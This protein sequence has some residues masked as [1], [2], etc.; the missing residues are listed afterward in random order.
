[1]TPV[2][3]AMSRLQQ[4]ADSHLE[5]VEEPQELDL[6][7]LESSRLSLSVDYFDIVEL[8]NEIISE[9]NPLI[10]EKKH[11]IDFEISKL[12]EE[13]Y[14]RAIHLLETNKEKLTQLANILIE[15]EVIFKDDLEAIFGKRPF[16]NE[17]EIPVVE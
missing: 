12:I 16:D 15:K 2:I 8:I 11:K 14:Q 9:L 4:L 1:M 7:K 17:E 6:S 10:L 5:M 3:E 13:Q